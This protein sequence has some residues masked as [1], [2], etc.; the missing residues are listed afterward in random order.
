MINSVSIIYEVQRKTYVIV[1]LV[2]LTMTNKKR[3]EGTKL[4]TVPYF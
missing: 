3:D 4:F 1:D 2:A